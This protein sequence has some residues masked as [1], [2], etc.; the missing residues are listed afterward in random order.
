MLFSVIIPH[1]NSFNLLQELIRTIPESNDIEIIVIDDHSKNPP[2]ENDFK[3]RNN[4]KILTN[5]SKGAGSARNLGILESSGKWL[6][7][8]DADDFFDVS[9]FGTIRK[10]ILEGGDIIYF[11]PSS[12]D[13]SLKRVGNRHKR[14]ENLVSDFLENRTYE[15]ENK[16]KLH[17]FVPWSKVYNKSFILKNKIYFDDILYSND[18]LFS[19]K[20]GMK[21]Q[22]IVCS[23]EVIYIVRESSDSLTKK[24]DKTAFNIRFDAALRFNKLLLN[25]GYK[26]H[27]MPLLKFVMWSRKF[28]IQC[29]FKTLLAVGKKENKLVNLKALKKYNSLGKVLSRYRELQK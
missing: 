22:K 17:F 3:Y 4:I 7:F 25:S 9:A 21:A 6:I 12:I 28:G 23:N 18:I 26:Q 14:Y 24:I 13:S 8:A 10:S 27:A 29:F 1:F 16:L 2:V 15:N 5:H 11:P 20:A 19:A